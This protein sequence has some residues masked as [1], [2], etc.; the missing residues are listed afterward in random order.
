M[1]PVIAC[2]MLIPQKNPQFYIFVA[3]LWI[4]KAKQSEGSLFK[5]INDTL[6]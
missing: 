4:N 5:F 3:K 1:N 2:L 6:Y